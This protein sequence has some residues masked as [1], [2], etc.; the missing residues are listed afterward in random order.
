MMFSKF[1]GKFSQNET[2]INSPHVTALETNVFQS[3]SAL[4]VKRLFATP[5]D[6]RR[7]LEKYFLLLTCSDL[8]R[9]VT[10]V[11]DSVCFSFCEM[12]RECSGRIDIEA[13]YVYALCW[14]DW[15]PQTA[16][17]RDP[18]YMSSLAFP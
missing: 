2:D 13:P 18:T 9:K 4:L 3:S 7:L 17:D 16:S 14:T 8:R 12:K 1:S 5:R 6:T 15:P 10:L 11:S